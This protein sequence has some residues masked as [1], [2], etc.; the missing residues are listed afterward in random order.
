MKAAQDVEG[1]LRE[2]LLAADRGSCALCSNGCA[3]RSCSSYFVE[4]CLVGVVATATLMLGAAGCS[5]SC[6]CHAI[7]CAPFHRSAAAHRATCTHYTLH[8]AAGAGSHDARTMRLV[9]GIGM[10]AGSISLAFVESVMAPP[11]TDDVGTPRSWLA[12]AAQS[13]CDT[14]EV[15]VRKPVAFRLQHGLRVTA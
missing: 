8:T 15:R 3:R 5:P 10:V 14:T 12:A 9:G 13:V 11:R 7:A 6:S 4:R 2:P 1:G